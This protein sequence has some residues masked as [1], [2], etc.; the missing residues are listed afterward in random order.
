VFCIIDNPVRAAA[1][2]I[3]LIVLLETTLPAAPA[4][5]VKAIIDPVAVVQLENTLFVM[6]FTGPLAT[7]APSLAIQPDMPDVPLTVILEKLLF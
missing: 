6:V 7:L 2:V 5:S 1:A 4:F 3:E